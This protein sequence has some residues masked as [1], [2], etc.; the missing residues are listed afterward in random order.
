MK[1]SRTNTKILKKQRRS[2][3]FQTKIIIFND[4]NK[5]ENFNSNLLN[6]QSSK[7]LPPPIN[8]MKSDSNKRRRTSVDIIIE[9]QDEAI[10]SPK[11]DFIRLE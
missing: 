4:N 2:Y 10:G 7:E 1:Q 8:L 9:A 5:R 11:D 6:I 3:L